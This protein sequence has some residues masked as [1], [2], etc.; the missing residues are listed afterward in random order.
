MK[1]AAALGVLALAGA[2]GLT[3]APDVPQQ[4]ARL[5]RTPIDY[6]RRLL[7][8]GQTRVLSELIEASRPLTDIFL[9]QV[10]EK[11]P[12]LR[13]RLTSA[14]AHHVEGAGDA[15]AYFRINAGPW[16]RL[17]GNAPFIGSAPKPPGAGFYPVDMT[18]GEFERWV[19]SHPGDRKAFE[20]LFTVIRRDGRGLTA[21]PYAREYRNFLEPAAGHLRQA[22]ALTSNA[23]LRAYFE[24]R[25]AALLDD[26]YYASDLAWMDVDSDLEAVIGPYEVYEDE[27]FNYKASFEAFVAVR[28]KAA[29]DAVAAY[30]AHL[31]DLERALPIPDPHK[32]TSRKSDS[33]IRVV[34][35]AFTAGDARTA[36]Q[37]S[38]FNLPNDERVRQ[39][40]GSKK[41]MLKNVM[42]AK[43]RVAGKPVAERVLDPAQLSAVSFDAFFQ[44]V[45][46]HELAHG[47]GPGIVAAPDG[48]KVEARLLLKDAYSTIEECKAD[49]VG[50]WALLRG[51][52][53]KWVTGVDADALAATVAGLFFRSIR[54]GVNEAHGGAEAIQW[55]W[56]REKGAIAPADSGRFRVDPARFRE[57]VA[58]LATELL[59]IEAKGDEARART[60]MASYGKMTPEM[61]RVAAGLK[62]IPVDLT[63]VY[64]AAGEK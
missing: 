8:A 25:A 51:I 54:F 12:E 6:D 10:S 5:P 61:E 59:L 43:F 27:L 19:A 62:D 14:S 50:A 22:A 48:R 2:A 13:R 49:V 29:S 31:P 4:L 40:R 34:Q 1:A 30:A 20:G 46:F 26:D 7:D 52:D 16:D 47:L 23:S 32:N 3:F 57:A 45:L 39:A 36:V 28:D 44:D 53:E 58:S 11:N 63:P 42:E 37:T 18:K 56:Y 17:D 9:R 21:I 15:L 24:K 33:P 38:A 64:P 35:V 55:S 41:V 60:L